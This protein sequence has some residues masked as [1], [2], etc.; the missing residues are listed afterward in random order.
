MFSRTTIPLAFVIAFILGFMSLLA[1]ASPIPVVPAVQGGIALFND[2][3]ARELVSVDVETRGPEPEP[4]L[5]IP[6]AVVEEVT[7]DP[8]RSS[9]PESQDDLEARICRFGCI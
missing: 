7:P 9:E 2:A 3:I 8:E 6:R 1:S 5:D 4:A